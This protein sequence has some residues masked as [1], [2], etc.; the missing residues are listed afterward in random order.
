MLTAKEFL[1][2]LHQGFFWHVWIEQSEAPSLKVM[3]GSASGESR[4]G[5]IRGLLM[6]NPIA[7]LL[8]AYATRQRFNWP[9]LALYILLHGSLLFALPTFSWEG[10]AVFFV[11]Y[12]CTTCLGITLC[13]HR[14]LAHRSYNTYRPIKYF[15]TLCGCLAFQRGPIWWSATH[16][17]HH[18]KVDTPQDPH[19]PSVSLLWSHYLW[20]FFRHPQLDESSETTQR[21]AL[22]LH[23]D[24]VMR[25]FEQHYTTI[26]VLF[27]GLLF[28][29]GFVRGGMDLGWSWLVWGGLLRLVY[30]LNVTWLVNSAAHIWGYRNYETPDTSRNNWLVAILTFGEGW[31]NN[32]HADQRAARSGH[33]WYELDVT[34]W[35]IALMHRLK[36]A[37][38]VVPLA[39]HYESIRPT[40]LKPLT[41]P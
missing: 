31:H 20:A 26:N 39:Q 27:M 1:G 12:F 24:G 11:L 17:L 35:L 16:R 5:L 32:H 36:L 3:A 25:F 7:H 6:K 9:L 13:Y 33:Y 41:T 38:N 37:M 29:I 15:L 28:G 4:H 23:K 19:S 40:R 22:D 10:L 14:L 30:T 21:L 34:Y 8:P 2:I 18:A